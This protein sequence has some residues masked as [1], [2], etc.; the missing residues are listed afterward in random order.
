M[1]SLR[2]LIEVEFSGDSYP[3]NKPEFE[4]LLMKSGYVRFAK[5]NENH[6]V[7]SDYWFNPEINETVEIIVFSNSR[8]APVFR[9]WKREDLKLIFPWN[10]IPE[11]A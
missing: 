11:A 5:N 9:D 2:H 6:M 4:S 7:E 10:K 3:L 8:W 1:G